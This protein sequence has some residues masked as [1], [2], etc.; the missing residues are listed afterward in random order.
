MYSF[1]ATQTSFKPVNLTTT[2]IRTNQSPRN[3]RRGREFCTEVKDVPDYREFYVTC[4]D[5]SG[6]ER[7]PLMVE[8]AIYTKE[9]GAEFMFTEIEIYEYNEL[10]GRCWGCIG[11]SK[12]ELLYGHTTRVTLWDTCRKPVY[13]SNVLL[14]A[15]FHANSVLSEK[16]RKLMRVWPNRLIPI[17]RARS[18]NFGAFF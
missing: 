12:T 18:F 7:Y 5:N 13:S 10:Q 2:L 14:C 11:E 4:R 9:V 3:L 16:C 1:L 6:K 8:L 17:W 15:N